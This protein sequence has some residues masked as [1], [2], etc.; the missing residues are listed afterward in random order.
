MCFTPLFSTHNRLLCWSCKILSVHPVDRGKYYSGEVCEGALVSLTRT[1][2]INA[3]IKRPTVD[4]RVTPTNSITG[5]KN[6]PKAAPSA[7]ERVTMIW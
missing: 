6:D 3:A 5:I 1:K 2:K 7:I 4:A